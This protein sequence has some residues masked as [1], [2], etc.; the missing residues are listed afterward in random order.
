MLTE[1]E[2]PLCPKYLESI[3]T[4]Y[5]YFHPPGTNLK[6]TLIGYGKEKSHSRH[7][8]WMGRR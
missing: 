8:G 1:R 5:E 2:I 7:H 6:I 4:Q 3:S